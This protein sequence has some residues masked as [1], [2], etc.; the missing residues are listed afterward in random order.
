MKPILR[1]LSRDVPAMLG[2][3]IVVFVLLLAI[4]GP[5]IAPYP[6]D[7]AAS[8]LTRRLKPPSADF[9]FGTDNLG[10]DI[11]SRIILGARGALAIALTVVTVAMAI[12]VPLGL[13]AGF[14]RGW[15][16]ETVMRVTD[17]VLA[18]P[19]PL[20][21]ATKTIAPMIL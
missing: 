17:V 21:P 11:F 12:G 14:R 4:F 8:H 13:L 15:L 5:L 19:Q 10:R 6:G 20:A 16:S 18:I 2:L 9:L 7:A 1:K 3:A